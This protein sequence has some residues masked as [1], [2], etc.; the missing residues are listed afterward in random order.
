V[1]TILSVSRFQFLVG[2]PPEDWDCNLGN[3]SALE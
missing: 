2:I 3:R 1:N